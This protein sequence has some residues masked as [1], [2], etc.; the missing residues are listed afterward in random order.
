MT[1]WTDEELEYWFMFH[2]DAKLGTGVYTVKKVTIFSSP[3]GMSLIILK[4]AQESIPPA[5][6]AWR[7]YTTTLFVLE[8][9]PELLKSLQIR[10]SC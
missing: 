8:T 9:I 3:A 6:V 1:T 10:L 7:A 4:R 5:Y 2:H